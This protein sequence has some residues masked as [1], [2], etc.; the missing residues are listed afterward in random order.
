M[1]L[2]YAR[3]STKEQH[4]E[5]QL[6][7]LK[8]HVSD[9]RYLFV[10]KISGRKENREGLLAL[11]KF[12][13]PGDTVYIHELDRLGRNKELI[14]Q[15]LSYFQ[16]NG[17]HVRVLELPTTMVDFTQYGEL[18]NAIMEM[19]N[20]ILVEV[21]STL[22]EQELRKNKKRQEEG[23]SSAKMRGVKFG[24]PK[25]VVPENWDFVIHE[26]KSGKITAVQAMKELNMTASTFYR[27]VKERGIL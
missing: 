9:E 10:D 27:R 3:V 13:R 23:I 25:V 15:E 22:A 20:N 19:I 8:K 12:A 17:I 26:W 16:K 5:R 1:N 6:E 7:E 11:K 21:L 14:K 2:G 24:R 18:G 4:L